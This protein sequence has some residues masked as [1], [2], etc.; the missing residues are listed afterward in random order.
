MANQLTSLH[1]AN[2]SAGGVFQ[3]FFAGEAHG[4]WCL[5]KY[6][7]SAPNC[8][9]D[10][11]IGCVIERIFLN[12]RPSNHNNAKPRSDIA[13]RR[14]HVNVFIEIHPLF[15]HLLRLFANPPNFTEMRYKKPK[16]G[17][18]ANWIF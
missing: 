18:I 15:R 6:W 5:R 12:A 9:W 4:C 10:I 7:W 3:V 17:Q 2:P 1:A 16:H 8:Y 11:K 14:G 13:N